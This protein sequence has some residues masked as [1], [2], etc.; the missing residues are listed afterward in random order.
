[1]V[2]LR[3]CLTTSPLDPN[4]G[5]GLP[6]PSPTATAPSTPMW[7]SWEEEDEE[8]VVDLSAAV[9]KR[10]RRSPAAAARIRQGLLQ[11]KEKKNRSR[12]ETE[13]RT[14]PSRLTEQMRGTRLIERLEEEASQVG[15]GA[16]HQG[17]SPGQ[18]EGETVFFCNYTK[19]SMHPQSSLPSFASMV[20]SPLL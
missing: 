15:R 7:R 4:W 14:T 16:V 6:A 3:P 9:Q 19:N 18:V 10:K 5:K 12:L 17:A 2:D 13:Q 20:T 8:E 11:W 1:M